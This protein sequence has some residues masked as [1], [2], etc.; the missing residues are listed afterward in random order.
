MSTSGTSSGSASIV[1][2]TS[3]SP[4]AGVPLT[5]TPVVTGSTVTTAAVSSTD[6]QN[7][8]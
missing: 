8:G 3:T 6:T 1:R 7:A 2:F 5:G 4:G